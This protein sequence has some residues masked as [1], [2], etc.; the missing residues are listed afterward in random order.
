MC[1]RFVHVLLRTVRYCSP[2]SNMHLYGLVNKT[3]E[4]FKEESDEKIVTVYSYSPL[5]YLV[6]AV[7]RGDSRCDASYQHFREYFNE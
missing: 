6:G 7:C 5:P 2:Y 4:T 3:Y 1:L